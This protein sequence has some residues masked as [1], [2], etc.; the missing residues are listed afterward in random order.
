MQQENVDLERRLVALENLIAL[1]LEERDRV[2]LR[3]EELNSRLL[4][5][6]AQIDDAKELIRLQDLQLSQL[7]AQLAETALP[8]ADEE[9]PTIRETSD[10]TEGFLE[11]ESSWGRARK[12]L[13]GFFQA[14]S[15]LITV[16]APLVL[17]FLAWLLWWDRRNY[18]ESRSGGVSEKTNNFHQGTN[19]SADPDV[20]VAIADIDDDVASELIQGEVSRE[21]PKL[22]STHLGSGNEQSEVE[23]IDFIGDSSDEDSFSDL[24]FLSDEERK[25][26]DSPEAVE[27]VFY[28]GDEESATKLELAY[29]YVKMNDLEGAREILLEVID[30]GNADQRKEAEKLLGRMDSTA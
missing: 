8:P 24:D 23:S 19:P 15:L 25:K 20:K 14:N 11:G 28:L 12:G 17:L 27:E 21:G 6:N 3:R 10:I 29:A 1:N 22:S 13:F 16:V 26:L 9:A 4:Q 2:R 5:L 7:R 30:E 18:A